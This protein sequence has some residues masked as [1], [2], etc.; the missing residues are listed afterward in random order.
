MVLALAA[1]LHRQGWTWRAALGCAPG[2]MDVDPD[3]WAVARQ[4]AGVR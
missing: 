2:W 4:L 1:M 3:A